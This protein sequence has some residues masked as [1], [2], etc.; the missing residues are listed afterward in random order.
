MEPPRGKVRTWKTA[1]PVGRLAHALSH[2]LRLRILVSLATGEASATTLSN[3]F[4]DVAVGE[5]SY[6]LAVL[7]EDCRLIERTWS[8]PVRGAT[9]TFF[10][11]RPRAKIGGFFEQL[12]EV[13]ADGLR[14]QWL[15]NFVEALVAALNAA[16][17]GKDGTIVTAIPIT[18]DKQGW[19][20]ITTTMREALDRVERAEIESRGRLDRAATADATTVILGVALF[21]PQSPGGP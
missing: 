7:A 10:R 12:P 9:E 18:V 3:R 21:E 6:H 5:V 1:T 11:L 17:T 14:V 4:G 8:R 15:R 20:E 19:A 16:A 13:L 2:P